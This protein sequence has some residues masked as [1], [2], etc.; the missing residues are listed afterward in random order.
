MHLHHEST[1]FTNLNGLRLLLILLAAHATY[2]QSDLTPEE[3]QEAIN[4]TPVKYCGRSL[5]LAIKTFCTPIMKTLIM[6]QARGGMQKKSLDF[7]HT[8]EHDFDFESFDV[9]RMA[10]ENYEDVEPIRSR[11]RLDDTYYA[12][13]LPFLFAQ[14]TAN[15]RRRR[16]IIEE[17]CRRACFKTDLI[18]YCPP[19]TKG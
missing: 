19:S 16:G 4:V 14:Q 1:P 7:T 17:C 18:R 13:D 11:F 10:L 3:I 12:N 15:G 9:D 6:A 8:P 2:V 5:N